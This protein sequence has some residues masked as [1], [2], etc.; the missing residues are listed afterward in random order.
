M[1]RP[2]WPNTASAPCRRL[3][4]LASE[5]DI[6]AIEALHERCSTQV[7]NGRYLGFPPPRAVE[8]LIRKTE[9]FI[10]PGDGE[11]LAMGN[12]ALRH[13][14]GARWAEVA[15]LVRDDHHRHGHATDLI[16]AMAGAAK[17]RGAREL[18]TITRPGYGL[19]AQV[20]SR[21]LGPVSVTIA[22]GLAS[23]TC[24]LYGATHSLL[25]VE[26]E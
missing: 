10:V 26:S 23:V 5:R 3:V 17:A 22:D 15:V 9:T 19:A 16:R 21:S 24:N 25:T 12:L 6:P 18:A 14:G 7:L 8:T 11:I 4:H 13:D 2:L 1:N 20:M